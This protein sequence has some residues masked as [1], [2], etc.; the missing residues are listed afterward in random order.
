MAELGLKGSPNKRPPKG[1]KMARV[2]SLDL[3]RWNFDRPAPILIW[4]TYIAEHPAR[5]HGLLLHRP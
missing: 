4:L 1:P 2:T 3:V 5:G